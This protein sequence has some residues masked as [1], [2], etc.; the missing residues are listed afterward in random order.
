MA[1]LAQSLILMVGTTCFAEWVRRKAGPPAIFA[2][3]YLV[4]PAVGLAFQ[5]AGVV[6]LVEPG[7]W[8]SVVVTGAITAALVAETV[9]ARSTIG[10]AI[11]AA[12]RDEWVREDAERATRERDAAVE[13]AEL[14]GRAYA[15][16]ALLEA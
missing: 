9:K 13:R 3:L 2:A 12:Q 4:F 15:V 10:Q 8:A 11:I 5:A 14:R 7:K 1:E 6:N 16:A